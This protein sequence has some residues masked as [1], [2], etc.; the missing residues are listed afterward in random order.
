MNTKKISSGYMTSQEIID[1]I[2]VL[3]N[4]HKISDGG[5]DEL[6]KAGEEIKNLAYITKIFLQKTSSMI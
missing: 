4:K 2:I 1:E 3:S 5:A 6:L